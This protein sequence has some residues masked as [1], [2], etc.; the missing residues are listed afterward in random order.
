MLLENNFLI[1]V[2]LEEQLEALRDNIFFG[3][4]LD[5]EKHNQK[6]NQEE[7]FFNLDEKN[8]QE[9][10]KVDKNHEETKKMLEIINTKLD[11]ISKEMSDIKESIKK[12]EIRNQKINSVFIQILTT[13]TKQFESIQSGKYLN[14]ITQEVKTLKN[15]ISKIN[16]K[17]EN[18]FKNIY[19]VVQEI[20]TK[21]EEN[22]K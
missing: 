12:N 8:S 1:S 13:L 19:A 11:L 9:E 21:M 3:K 6:N 15:V 16:E 14:K 2:T 22:K 5:L 17:Y 18:A 20:L 10:E 7:I 4:K